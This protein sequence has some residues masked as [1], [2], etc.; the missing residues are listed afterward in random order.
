MEIKPLVPRRQATRDT[1]D[2]VAYYLHEDAEQ[3]A[4]AF[5]ASLERAYA[6]TSRE[7]AESARYAHALDL[8]GLRSWLLARFAHSAF[9]IEHSD[10]IVVWRVSHG[11]R[12]NTA[13]PGEPDPA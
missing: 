2:T 1:D 5:I 11:Q 7:P 13:W 12:A 6:Q 4:L 3:P 9:Y 10:H 8:P